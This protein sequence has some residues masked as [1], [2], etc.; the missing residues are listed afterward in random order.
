M[1]RVLEFAKTV[2]DLRAI[3][4]LPHRELR[5][6]HV[7]GADDALLDLLHREAGI[8]RTMGRANKVIPIGAHDGRPPHAISRRMGQVEVLLPVDA[9]FIEKERAALR[10]EI[11]KTRAE[12]AGLERKLAA[13]GFLEKA[14]AEVVQKEQAR[15]KELRAHVAM[16][17]ER[18]AS[19]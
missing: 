3:G 16:S 5:D 4:L 14:P 2:R 19:L 13:K 11:E 1:A 9:A 15:L 12:I 6:V 10:K 18:L 8:V 7:A 17:S